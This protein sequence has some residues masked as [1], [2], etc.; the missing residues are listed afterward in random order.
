LSIEYF[1]IDDVEKLM[2]RYPGSEGLRDTFVREVT[3]PVTA[4]EIAE[5]AREGLIEFGPKATTTNACVLTGAFLSD[6]AVALALRTQPEAVA[7]LSFQDTTVTIATLVPP[8]RPI[9]KRA[10]FVRCRILGPA[11]LVMPGTTI[12]NCSLDVGKWHIPPNV[13]PKGGILVQDSIFESCS[14]EGV[15]VATWGQDRFP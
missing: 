11:V 14:F 10:R 7:D 1:A 15:G 4:V 3:F 9:L 12:T 13:M 5:T 8:D 6:N 2:L